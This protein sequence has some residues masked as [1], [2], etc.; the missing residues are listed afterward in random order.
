MNTKPRTIA[1]SDG[2]SVALRILE[3]LFLVLTAVFL[4]HA[5]KGMT[6]FKPTISNDFLP[7]LQLVMEL[8]VLALLVLRKHERP[9]IWLGLI[10]VWTY[11]KTSW[12]AEITRTVFIAILVLGLEGIDHRRI[13][14][15][16][17]AVVGSA[18]VATVIAGMGGGIPNLVYT[19]AG[20]QG[21]LRSS[22]GTA[23]PTDFSTMVLFLTMAVW[24]A[25]PTLPDWAML[26]FGLIPLA[27]AYFV[28]VSRNSMLC[29]LL[30]EMVIV[31]HWLE[32]GALV[33]S[34]WMK[35][36]RRGVDVL[37]MAAAPM[38]AVLIYALVYLYAKNPVAMEPLNNLMSFR[39]QISA[40]A[41]Q[42]YPLVPFGQKVV[43]N[44]GNGGTIFSK[45]E[46]LFLDSSY[47]NMLLRYGWVTML[48]VF[49]VWEWML[50]KALRSGNR[51]MALV[52]A[53]V[54]FH[55]IMEHHFPDPFD[56]IL[57]IMPLAALKVPPL[58]ALPE[59]EKRRRYVAFAMV[60]AAMLALGALFLPRIMSSLR[61][62]YSAKG[63]QGGYEN[64]WPVVGLNLCIVM[65]CVAGAWA[66]YRLLN[67]ALTRRGGARV[68]ACVLA[69]CLALGIGMGVWGDRVIA[70]ATQANAAMVDAD[71]DVLNC[72]SECGIHSDVMPEVYRRRFPNVRRS[73]LGG[74]DLARLEDAVVLME[75]QP[76]H[77][78][79]IDHGFKYL[80]ISDKHALYV[81]DPKALDALKAG[82]YV[83]S[84]YYSKAIEVD[85][86]KLS[87]SNKLDW[88]EG[89]LLLNGPKKSLTKGPNDD[90]FSGNYAVEYSLFLPEDA[91]DQKGEICALRVVNRTNGELTRVTVNRDQFD[92]DGRATLIVPVTLVG[93]TIN[94]RFQVIAEKRRKV[95]VAGIRYWQT[96]A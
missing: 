4:L 85:L 79:F 83:A 39:L 5:M 26:L 82:G 36:I 72:L 37:L 32:S 28:T 64:A 38:C 33:R 14:K 52:M 69:L 30:F 65:L 22:W 16:F 67:T 74:D 1:R 51:R 59:R 78:V 13:L 77:R 44:G 21:G 11:V 53:V 56:N 94:V 31:Y 54:A 50:H 12:S 42:T 2:K 90:L 34:G 27:L 61:T 86:E 49:A 60:A 25:W 89:G 63:W 80:Q 3:D 10:L 19:L 87:K 24:M 93:D 75:N 35:R 57:L 96:P 62:I 70:Q 88:V 95:G 45:G 81:S 92:S 7:E 91:M 73:V 84:D 20:G 47:V 9:D 41:M 15:V 66:S 6:M 40:K 58:E 68:A 71:A 29:G 43:M 76:E 23:Y 48:A 55:S 18:L 17:I 46:M 8:V